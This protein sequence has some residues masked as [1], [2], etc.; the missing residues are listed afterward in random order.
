[1]AAMPEKPQ[2]KGQK[3]FPKVQK[4]ATNSNFL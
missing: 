2:T 3:D 4:V 1:M